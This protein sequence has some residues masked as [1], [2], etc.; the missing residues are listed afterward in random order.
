V[1]RPLKLSRK[2]RAGRSALRPQ[3]V[4]K[5]DKSGV[6]SSFFQVKIKPLILFVY[7]SD[8]LGAKPR[9]SAFVNRL[10]AQRPFFRD[11]NN[12]KTEYRSGHYS[13]YSGRNFSDPSR[14]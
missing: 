10:S 9:V 13:Q 4:I 14:C 1:S 6:L 12:E 11:R 7:F 5:E 2:A 8:F 3:I